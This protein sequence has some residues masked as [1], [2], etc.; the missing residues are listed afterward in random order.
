MTSQDA[1][2]RP[3]FPQAEM[4]R[5]PSEATSSLTPRPRVFPLSGKSEDPDWRPGGICAAGAA[6]RCPC[7]YCTLDPRGGLCYANRCDAPHSSDIRPASGPSSARESPTGVS[8]PTLERRPRSRIFD[9]TGPLPPRVREVRGAAVRSGR[10]SGWPHQTA[11][12]GS[13]RGDGEEKWGRAYRQP[14]S[15]VRRG[16]LPSPKKREASMAPP[17]RPEPTAAPSAASRAYQR[18]PR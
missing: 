10:S 18:S 3:V 16:S 4:R 13:G 12:A 11:Q 1:A 15:A 6:F 8:G 9:Y 5:L 2:A 17:A 7:A 14:S